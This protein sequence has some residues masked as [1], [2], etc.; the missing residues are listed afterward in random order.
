MHVLDSVCLQ[1]EQVQSVSAPAPGFEEIVRS[2]GKCRST[3][4]D[5]TTPYNQYVKKAIPAIINTKLNRTERKVN[6]VIPN[7][8]NAMLI[9]RTQRCSVGA[10]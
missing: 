4:R 5:L 3:S 2:S 10:L 7:K 1:I 6:R 8:T 9:I